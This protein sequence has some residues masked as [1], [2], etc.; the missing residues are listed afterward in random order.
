MPAALARGAL[1]FALWLVLS[2]AEPAGLPFGALAALLATRASLRLL[3]PRPG[4]IDP[5]ALLRLL[6]LVLRQSVAAGFDVALRAFA[7]PPRLSPGLVEVPLAL[8][9]GPAR[10]AYRALASLAPGAL[11]LTDTQAGRLPLHALDTGLPLAAD[12]AASAAAFAR[13]LVVRTDG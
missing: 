4:R 13:S 8:P 6:F 9:P 2:G 12:S 10:D 11:P 5:L 3:P 1:F 7:R